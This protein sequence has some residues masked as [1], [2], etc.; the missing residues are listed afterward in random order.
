M[1]FCFRVLTLSLV[2]SLSVCVSNVLNFCTNKQ[3]IPVDFQNS[4]RLKHN[5]L[6]PTFSGDPHLYIHLQ[7]KD[8]N[9]EQTDLPKQV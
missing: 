1:C 2:L 6:C 5:Y 3:C 9:R 4:D 7:M 8:E